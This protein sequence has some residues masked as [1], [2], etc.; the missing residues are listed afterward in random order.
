MNL[1][2]APQTV[3]RTVVTLGEAPLG[4]DDVENVALGHARIEL[5]DTPEVAA[6]L[7]RGAA[8]LEVLL[9]SG[10]R[11]YGVNTGFGDSC[12][13][14][15]P[16]EHRLDLPH[17]L[18]RFHGCGTG[19]S[20]SPVEAAAIAVT[21]LASLVSGAS[22]VRPVLIERLCQLVNHR[23]LP[24]IPCEGSVGASGDLTPLS[25]LAAALL[26]ERELLLE[27]GEVLPA[28]LVLERLGPFRLSP[29]ESL[30][31]MNGTSAMTGLACL[32]FQRARRLGRFAAAL[33]AVASDVMRGQPGHFDDRLFSLK[34]HPGQRA[35]AG[36]IRDDL[37]SPPATPSNA[38]AR[39]V[40]PARLQDRYSLR[41]A[42]HVIGVLLDN[43]PHARAV[44]ETELNSTNDNPVLDLETG[45]VLHGG[46]FYG[47]HICQ[48]MDTL[49]TCIAN[50]ADLCDR[51]LALLCD[52]R[53][54]GG[55]PDNLVLDRAP[56][57][58]GFKAMQISASALCAEALKLTM[59][60]SVFSRSTENHNQDKV[61]MGTIAARD[62]LRIL[63]L[64]ETVAAIHALALCQ[65]VDLRSAMSCCPR[66]RELHAAVRRQVAV[67][68]TDRR[69]DLDIAAVLELYR[70]RKLPLGSADFPPPRSSV[71]GKP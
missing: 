11:V 33:T 32:A 36:W 58:H 39:P 12:E 63:D 27:T 24:K 34:P 57:Q 1:P 49:K 61:S 68:T 64:T 31:L 5:S 29:K 56:S 19:A 60:A 26:G 62:C 44:I 55:L 43:L 54:N 17:N 71:R 20:F 52:S 8:V 67:N 35:C 37:G 42:P 41:C 65:A 13:T 59:P 50:L 30:A 40:T 9:A 21:R 70:E 46:N 22:G 10:R 16:A 3:D 53:T 45:E 23:L 38:A 7:A 66:A 28:S 47:G 6:R 48:A 18:I 69:M 15:V 14:D 4:I 51:Q 25:Y 2:S